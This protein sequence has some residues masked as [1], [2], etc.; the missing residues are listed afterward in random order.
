MKRHLEMS[1]QT[2][3]NSMESVTF[4]LLSHK[5]YTPF[6]T[7]LLCSILNLF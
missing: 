6:H 2:S 1:P 5:S 7:S 4:Q 3:H